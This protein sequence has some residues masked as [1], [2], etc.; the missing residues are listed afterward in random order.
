M[1]D[2]SIQTGGLETGGAPPRARRSASADSALARLSRDV[3]GALLHDLVVPTG[4]SP[5]VQRRRAGLIVSRVRWVA[6]VFAILTP[7]WIGVDLTIFP[8]PLAWWLAGLRVMASA[9]FAAVALGFRNTESMRTANLALGALLAVPTVFFLISD[10]L[11][12]GY[13]I[14]GYAQA[15]AAG[16][17]FLPFVMVAGL[18]VFPITASEGAIFSAPLILATIGIVL[19][20]FELLPFRTYLGALWLLGLIAVV[21]TLAG[22]SQ[23]HFMMQLVNQASHDALTQVYTRRVGEELLDSQFSTAARSGVPLSLAF[24]DLDNFKMV[25][26]RYGHEE[27]DNTLRKATEQIRKVVRRG[28]IVIRWGGEEFLV[29]MPGT[30]A[31]GA[32]VAIERLRAEG[33]GTRPDGARQTASIGVAER[34]SDNAADWGDLVE[35]A[36]QRMYVAK[37]SGRDRVVTIGDEMFQ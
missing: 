11:V 16:Y 17:A 31:P 21:A 18:S 2:D 24:L 1:R 13:Q 37:K 22:M 26:D 25:N 29:V 4:H 3:T 12:S 27:G 7:L 14:T 15:L 36:D 32:R 23:L 28:D 6:A 10:P 8:E 34:L 20:D 35:R 19:G 33:L 9:A 5:L 30:D